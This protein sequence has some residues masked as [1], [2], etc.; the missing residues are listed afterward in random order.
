VTRVRTA[1]AAGC[2]VFLLAAGGCSTGGPPAPAAVVGGEPIPGRDV[3]RLS[4]QLRASERQAAHSPIGPDGGPRALPE[5][6]L[7]QL[8]LSQLVKAKVVAQLASREGVTARADEMARSASGQLA[9]TE[10]SDAGWGKGDFEM[11]VRSSILSKVLAEKLFPTIDIADD[12]MRAYFDAHPD[13]FRPTWKATVDLAFFPTE[14]QAKALTAISGA[15]ARF[16][17]AARQAGATDVLADQAVDQASPLPAEIL[18]AIGA[19]HPHT[20]S[21]P[22]SVPKGYW[23]VNAGDVTAVAAQTFEAA[24]PSIHDHLADQERQT[25]FATWLT[26]QLRTADVRVNRHYGRWPQDFVL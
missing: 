6:R 17:D 8:V 14:A 2:L 12:A 15:P 7:H 10:F 26:E 19:L 11:A 21:A 25:K 13:L 1:A 18:T 4:Q 20:V 5:K 22:I 9:S 16:A 23:V 3:D 24:R